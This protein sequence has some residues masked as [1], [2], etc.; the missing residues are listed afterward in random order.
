[1]S[2]KVETYSAK[3]LVVSSEVQA[4]EDVVRRL[5]KGKLTKKIQLKNKLTKK[6]QLKGV[7]K[8]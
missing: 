6:I 1:M 5:I 3:F 2:Y 8:K 7:V 4:G